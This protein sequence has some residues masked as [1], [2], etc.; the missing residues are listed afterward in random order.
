MGSPPD[1]GIETIKEVMHVFDYIVIGAGS[2]G[3][4]MAAR[5]AEAHSVLL[6]EAGRA[7]PAWDFRLH[8]PAALSE[9]LTSTRYNWAFETEPEP[10][11][12]SATCTVPAAKWWADPL[13]LTA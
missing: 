13:Q 11:W 10:F 7:N 3:C 6:I 1:S 9:V 4:V 12:G 2:A 8:M 5:L